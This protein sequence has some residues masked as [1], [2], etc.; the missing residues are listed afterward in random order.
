MSAALA[1]KTENNP[2]RRRFVRLTA[3]VA[4]VLSVF[5]LTA[6]PAMAST[7]HPQTVTKTESF[8]SPPRMVWKWDEVVIQLNNPQSQQFASTG[9]GAITG[10]KTLSYVKGLL[11]DRASDLALS[12]LPK[13]Y[14][15]ELHVSWMHPSYDWL[16]RC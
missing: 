16:Y 8:F 5:G 4:L 13:G 10:L 9:V 2:V 1:Q 6:A 7:V 15:V 11:A 3:T 14:C 12:S